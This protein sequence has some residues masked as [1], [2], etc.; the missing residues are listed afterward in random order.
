MRYGRVL[1]LIALIAPSFAWNFNNLF[2]NSEVVNGEIYL[3]P[4]SPKE[5]SPERIKRQAY[6]VYV[7]GD[8]SVSVDKGGQQESGVWGQWTKDRECSRTCGGG[9]LIEKRQ[10][11]GQCS[12]PSVRYVSCNIEPCESGSKD[13]RAEQC[14][15]HNDDPLDGNYYKWLPY[16]GKNKCELLCKPDTANFYYKWADKVVDGTKCDHSSDDICVEG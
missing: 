2:S 4:L 12:G 10:C 1:L 13:F 3:H 5:S 6:Q 15:Q 9:V 16:T 7:G 8:T 11:N 14:S